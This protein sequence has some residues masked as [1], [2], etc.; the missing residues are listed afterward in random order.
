M[1]LVHLTWKSE[2]LPS[3]TNTE[4]SGSQTWKDVAKCPKLHSGGHTSAQVK[5]RGGLLPYTGLFFGLFH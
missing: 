1:I 4:N 5:V 2:K 3:N